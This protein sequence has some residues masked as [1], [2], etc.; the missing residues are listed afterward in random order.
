MYGLLVALCYLPRLGREERAEGPG[1]LGRGPRDCPPHDS[2]YRFPIA[3]AVAAL[4]LSLTQD[5][6]NNTP[7][8]GWGQ[9][10]RRRTRH[11]S[12]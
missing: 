8:A 4:V 2:A 5:A 9:G 6:V 1:L 12:E 3:S 10:E 11:R 7:K